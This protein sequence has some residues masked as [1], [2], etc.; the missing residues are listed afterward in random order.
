MDNNGSIANDMANAT[1]IEIDLAGDNGIIGF[2]DLPATYKAPCIT[3]ERIRAKAHVQTMDFVTVK[4]DVFVLKPRKKFTL[5]QLF[6]IATILNRNR[7]RFSYHRKVT[8]PRLEKIQFHIDENKR[9][10]Q[11]V[12]I[13]SPG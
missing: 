8:K 9:T 1:I 11:I 3:I 2:V 7:W 13:A 10:A 5:G 4:C 12:N 6:F